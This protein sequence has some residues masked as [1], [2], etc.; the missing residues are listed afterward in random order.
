MTDIDINPQADQT[1]SNYQPVVLTSDAPT[2]WRPQPNRAQRRE[3]ER[4]QRFQQNVTGAGMNSLH[5]QDAV[6][7]SVAA[8]SVKK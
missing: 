1:R 4:R 7:I 6:D 5:A 2:E 8:G 3:I